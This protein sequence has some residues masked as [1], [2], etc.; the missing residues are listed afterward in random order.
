M[1]VP[2]GMGFV[3]LDKYSKLSGLADLGAREF[4][5]YDEETE[6][7]TYDAAIIRSQCP[8][9]MLAPG[10]KVLPI[11]VKPGQYQEPVLEP[12]ETVPKRPGFLT[13]PGMPAMS[14]FGDPLPGGPLQRMRWHAPPTD[15]FGLEQ[16]WV[17]GMPT[18]RQLYWQPQPSIFNGMGDLGFW[19]VVAPTGGMI[20]AFRCRPYYAESDLAITQSTGAFRTL[21]QRGAAEFPVGTTRLRTRGFHTVRR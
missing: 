10:Y 3:E 8:P 19:S 15:V 20:A 14:G 11:G 13:P 17:P 4:Y 21:V 16:G 9:M 1:I 5:I 7:Q 18:T 12:G 2:E 6:E